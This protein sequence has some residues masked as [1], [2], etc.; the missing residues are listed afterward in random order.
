MATIP[1]VFA[2]GGDPVQ[3]G[4]VASLSCPGGNITDANYFY[5]A[6]TPKRLELLRALV[7][8]A[9]LEGFLANPSNP[10]FESEMRATQDAAGALGLRLH[11]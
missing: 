4:I 2:I 6:L 10:S 8:T 9:S 11:F 3:L 7:P 1:I 5:N